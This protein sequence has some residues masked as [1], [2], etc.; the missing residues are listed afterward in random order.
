MLNI[1]QKPQ[2]QLKAEERVKK[3]PLKN[4]LSL[5]NGSEIHFVNVENESC[6][7]GLDLIET[8]LT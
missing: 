5:K 2:E 4:F 1:E 7:V 8:V 6:L 3:S